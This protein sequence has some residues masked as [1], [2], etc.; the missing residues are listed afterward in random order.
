MFDV[1]IIGA[2][3]AGTAAAYDLLSAGMKVLILDKKDFPRKKACAGGITPKG[4]KLFRYDISSVVRQVCHTVKVRQ[5]NQTSFLIQNDSPLCYMTQRKELDAFSLTKV[6]EK[7]GVF[8][9]ARKIHE[10]RQKRHTVEIHTDIGIFNTSFLI[11]AD[12]AGSRV[13]RMIT[14]ASTSSFQF[15]LEADVF[16]D[17]PDQFEMEFDF[18]G[19]HRGYFWI[20][21]K[22]DHVNIGIYS[23]EKANRPKT[24]MLRQYAQNRVGHKK[25]I[26][27]KGYP[28]CTGGY[29]FTPGS[30]R[31][32]LAGDAAGFAEKLLGEGIYFAV[33][34]G[35][36]AAEAILHTGLKNAGQV[37]PCYLKVLNSLK[38]DLRLHN[39]SAS[40]L[41]RFPGLSLHLLSLPVIHRYF[42]N[43][44]GHGKTLTQILSI[45]GNLAAG[46][47]FLNQPRDIPDRPD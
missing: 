2:G 7:G 38:M 43:G 40:W 33:K 28:I 18:S 24:D 32:L 26:D 21:P 41:Y 20:F 39:L 13:R 5:K 47:S 25:L 44:Y 3:P 23:I 14:P 6:I 11:G 19:G 17:R 37:L 34:S 31:I 16:V 4:M 1:I 15:A 30:G 36:A 9:V 27:V 45:P 29:G 10:I 46:L 8:Q 22:A 35:Q 12:G 42:A